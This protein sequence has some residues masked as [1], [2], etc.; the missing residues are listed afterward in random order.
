MGSLT[1][2]NN[3]TLQHQL[4]NAKVKCVSLLANYKKTGR[5]NRVL[6]SEIWHNSGLVKH[7]AHEDVFVTLLD[8]FDLLCEL[9]PDV[10]AP[11]VSHTHTHTH[12]HP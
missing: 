6:L 10:T 11:A 7:K 8:R 12:T 2:I 5:L 3:T 4:D 9:M 1:L